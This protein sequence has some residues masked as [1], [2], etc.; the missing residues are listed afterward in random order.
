VA[1]YTIQY[2]VD[3]TDYSP[4]GSGGWDSSSVPYSGPV[5]GPF[6]VPN[7]KHPLIFLAH[8][9]HSGCDVV[10]QEQSLEALHERA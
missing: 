10:F 3:G 6:S 1:T 7:L 2:N 8:S 4:N 9:K 5:I